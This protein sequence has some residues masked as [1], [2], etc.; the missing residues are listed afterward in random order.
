MLPHIPVIG[1]GDVLDWREF[2]EHQ[3]NAGTTTVMLARG[4]LIK[5]WLPREI[6]G[7]V[8][9]DVRSSERLDMLKDYVNYGC[10]SRGGPRKSLRAQSHQ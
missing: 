3:E 9:I 7:R 8:D 6:R 4:A 5:P 1:N 2:Y 10:V